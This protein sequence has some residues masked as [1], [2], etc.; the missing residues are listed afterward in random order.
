MVVSAA[1]DID[2]L[3]RL[4]SEEAY[5]NWHH[6]LAHNLAFALVLSAVCAAFSQH[7]AKSFV[8]YLTLIHL[9]FLMDLLGSGPGWGIYYFWPLSRWIANNP[10]SWPLYSWQNLCFAGIFFL[11]V[12][13]IAVYDGRTPLEAV[14]PDLDAKLVKALRRAAIWRH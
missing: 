11:W 6:V 8:V 9:H 5:W 7:R 14:M 2:G 3:G 10:Y 13:A 4:W 12:L 1:P